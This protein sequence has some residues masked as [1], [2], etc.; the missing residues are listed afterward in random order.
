MTKKRQ[1]V[2]DVL[3]R[4]GTPLNAQQ[5]YEEVEGSLDRATVYRTLKYL[6]ELKHI[7]SFIFDCNERGI[8][9]YYC[10]MDK[11]HQHYMHCHCCHHFFPVKKCPLGN[12]LEVLEEETG[13]KVEQHSITLK[14]ICRDCR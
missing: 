3:A 7:S 2:S 4:K 6:E 5:V 10:T 11:G 12:E 8:E 9:R 14:G 13:F 1:L